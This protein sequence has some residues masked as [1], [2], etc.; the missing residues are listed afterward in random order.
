MRRESETKVKVDKDVQTAVDERYNSH[1]NSI[2]ETSVI[3]M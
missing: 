1:D 2:S 3:W